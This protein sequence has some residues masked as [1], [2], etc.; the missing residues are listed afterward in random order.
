MSAQQPRNE[1]ENMVEIKNSGG[2]TNVDSDEL[3]F[4]IQ[5]TIEHNLAQF[6]QDNE[7]IMPSDEEIESFVNILPKK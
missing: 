5:D 7:H 6:S 2:N 3:F 4:F 1:I